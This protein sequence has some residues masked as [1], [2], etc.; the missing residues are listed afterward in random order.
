MSRFD[1]PEDYALSYEPDHLVLM[2]RDAHFGGSF[3]VMLDYYRNEGKGI[4]P[5]IE[6]SQIEEM[7]AAEKNTKQ[8]MA[9]LLLSGAEAELVAQSRALYQKLKKA[10]EFPQPKNPIPTLM[11]HLILSEDPHPEAEIAAIVKEK[12][13]IVPALIELI[14]SEEFYNPLFPGY[15]HA[16][17]LAAECLGQIGDKRA[18][19]AL[20]EA[21]GEADFFDEEA[22]IKALGAI[23]ASA[24]EFLL[25]VLHA[26]PLNAD[27]D[28]AAIALMAFKDDP[29]VAEQC[30][31]MLRDPDV[32]KHLPISTYLVLASEQLASQEDRQHFRNMAKADT[33]PRLLRQDMQTILAHWDGKA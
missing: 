14:K 25:R 13:A 1:D 27:N 23:G 7:A 20:F 15:G 12:G 17:A 6:L 19:V 4:C 26:R 31:A 8:N 18:I 2:H 11:A 21:I 22:I 3:D 28:R 32:L 29:E 10:C 24:K 5:D 9:P 30:F 33:T 16:P